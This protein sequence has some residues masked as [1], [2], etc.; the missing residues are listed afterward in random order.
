MPKR[1]LNNCDVFKVNPFPV[2][3]FTVHNVMAVLT[4]LFTMTH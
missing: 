1:R 4:T 3:F 2:F